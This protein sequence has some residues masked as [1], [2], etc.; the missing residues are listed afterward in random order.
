MG[1]RYYA[2]WLARWTSADPAGF[3][4]GTNR[5]QYARCNPIVFVDRDGREIE[6]YVTTSGR[7]GN[8]A[9][10]LFLGIAAHRLIGWSYQHPSNV[11]DINERVYL[12][13]VPIKTIL[14]DSKIGDSSKLTKA[15][16][17]LKPDITNTSIYEVFE[18]KPYTLQKTG[19]DEVLE[20]Q[21]ALNK[22][23][24]DDEH[25][26][27]GSKHFAGHL[28]VKFAG[29]KFVWDLQ[30]WTP[31]PGVT[32]YRWRRLNLKDKDAENKDAIKRA[33]E[34]D[35]WIEVPDDELQ[36]YGEQVSK[37]IEA[38]LGT[39]DRAEA[40][41]GIANG[42]IDLVGNSATGFI[43]GSMSQ[44]LSGKVAPA[45]APAAPAPAKPLAPIVPLRP[46]APPQA[47][48][49]PVFKKAA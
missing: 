42:F 11:P 44:G 15:E 23:T 45:A 7:P 13:V 35:N 14:D 9:D 36:R 24:D 31:E 28:A 34:N 26:D 20:Y 22:T 2:P 32:L 4:D 16:G 21:R 46:P 5:Y 3:G 43:M 49:A 12:N 8:Q 37:S 6:A 17:N 18:I 38:Y 27:L 48:P 10:A 1:A 40:V 25:F 47:A 41:E 19:H 39:S 33:Y 30:W 29:G